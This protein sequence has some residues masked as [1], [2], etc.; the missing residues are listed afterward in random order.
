MAVRHQGRVSFSLLEALLVKGA[1][2]LVQTCA[3]LEVGL[4]WSQRRSVR[5]FASLK[6]N[7][8][9]KKLVKLLQIF[10]CGQ[11]AG[12]ESDVVGQQF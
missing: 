2:S 5:C 8:A 12:K 3:Q 1:S 7:R 10:V 11:P 6:G 4:S 9:V